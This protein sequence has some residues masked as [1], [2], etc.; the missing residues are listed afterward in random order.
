MPTSVLFIA[1]NRP[2]PGSEERAYGYLFNEGLPYLRSLAGQAFERYELIG[3]TAHRSDL[4]ACII[5]FGERQNLDELRRSDGFEAFAV[6]M[7]GL[8]DRFGVV[9]GV[10]EA[11]ILAAMARRA[12]AKP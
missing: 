2:L 3:L 5:L 10:N 1:W 4:N 9:P 11:G 7:N 12:A 6:S 8:F